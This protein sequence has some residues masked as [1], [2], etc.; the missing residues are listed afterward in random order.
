M[1]PRAATRRIYRSPARVTAG[2][3]TKWSLL[4]PGRMTSRGASYEVAV[5]ATR[6]YDVPATQAP[7]PSWMV[8]TWCRPVIRRMRSSRGSL[9]TSSK[10]PPAGDLRL[11]RPDEY[12][13]PGGVHERDAVE[14]Y[15]DLLLPLVEDVVQPPAQER[16]GVHVDL[17]AERDVGA[18]LA[19]PDVGLEDRGE[20]EDPRGC[21]LGCHAPTL[22]W[23]G[24]SPGIR[25]G[26]QVGGLSTQMT[27]SIRSRSKAE[28]WPR[29]SSHSARLLRRK[30]S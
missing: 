4:P 17:A 1:S 14:V 13:E 16:C 19:E 10:D 21:A 30:N 12:A 29:Y 2:R 18:G 25:T 5:I 8:R 15:D 24:G 7:V 11:V 27:G 6:T 22:P 26:T 23:T 20:G 9:Q 3:H 28:T